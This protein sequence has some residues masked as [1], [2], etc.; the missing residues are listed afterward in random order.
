MPEAVEEAAVPEEAANQAE[1]QVPEEAV[2]PEEIAVQVEIP[3][4]KAN[5]V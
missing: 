3:E 2:A 4:Q 5:R 1:V